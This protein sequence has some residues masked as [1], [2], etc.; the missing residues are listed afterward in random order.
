MLKRVAGKREG[1]VDMNSAGVIAHNIWG[2][3]QED[4]EKQKQ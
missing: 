2:N 1:V 4:A 3:D